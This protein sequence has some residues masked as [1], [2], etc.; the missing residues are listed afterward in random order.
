MSIDQYLNKV[1]QLANNLKI[2][3]KTQVLADLDEDYTPIVVLVNSKDHIS[4][5]EL[6]STLMT[7]EN[8]LEHLNLIRNEMAGISID[9]TLANHSR[10]FGFS[11]HHYR[12]NQPNMGGTF[13]NFNHITEVAE[14]VEINERVYMEMTG[15]FATYVGKLGTKQMCV[16]SDMMKDILDITKSKDQ[17]QP[18]TKNSH[19]F[20]E[21]RK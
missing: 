10:R 14:E 16:T 17:L 8:R 18:F 4:W 5:G 3:G 1:K 13:T 15:Q 12:S 2:A 21:Y 19:S 9:Q 7:Y 20:S 6:Q 11:H